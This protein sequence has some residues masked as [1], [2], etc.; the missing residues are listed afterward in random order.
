MRTEY[1]VYF[2]ATDAAPSEYVI[3]TNRHERDAFVACG[4][5]DVSDNDA[6]WAAWEAD[7]IATARGRAGAYWGADA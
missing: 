2:T 5:R 7:R 4:G 3:A 1:L 6:D